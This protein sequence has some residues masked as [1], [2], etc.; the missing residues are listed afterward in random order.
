MLQARDICYALYFCDYY[1]V[2]RNDIIIQ[3]TAMLTG[4]GAQVLMR[5]VGSGCKYR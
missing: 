2:M 1:I 3:L 5:V 4:G